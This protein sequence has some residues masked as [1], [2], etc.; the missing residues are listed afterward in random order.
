M[1]PFRVNADYEVELFRKMLAPHAINQ[2]IEF[3]LFF[4]NDRPLWSLKNY[5]PEYL[6]H[7][8]ALTNRAPKIVHSGPYENFWGPLKDIETEKWWNSKITSTQ[9]IIDQKW[10]GKTQILNQASNLDFLQ[11]GHTYLLKDPFGMSGQKFQI[12][13]NNSKAFL[14]K[15]LSSGVQII[16]PWL[17]RQFDFSQYVFPD[18]KVIAYENLVDAKFQYKGTTF[19]HY[20]GASLN[21]LSFYSKIPKEEWDIFQDQT[22]QIIH[23]YSKFPNLNGYSIDSFIYKESGELKIRVMS[24]INYRWTMGRVAY[25]LSQKFAPDPGWSRLLLLKRPETSQHLWNVLAPLKNIWVLSPGDSRFE[26]FF[27]SAEN[28]REG[29]TLMLKMNELLANS[30]TS[31][32]I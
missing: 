24:E 18:G 11:D 4:L 6:S 17:D 26:I 28:E 32:E 13:N 14:E 29:E 23:H 20:P 9:F 8:E 22:Q 30:K 25:E 1:K 5:S 3:F 16:E 15:A 12:L 27:L 7:V 10:C 31:V 21:H 2:S 19:H